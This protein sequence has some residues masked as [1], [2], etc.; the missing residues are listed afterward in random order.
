RV[1]SLPRF[2]LTSASRRGSALNRGL[3]VVG[4]L[5]AFG[6]SLSVFTATYDQ[7]AR[8]DAQ[9]TLGADVVATAPPGAVAKAHL[10]RTIAGVPGVGGTS[11]LDHTYAYVGPDLQDTFGIDPRTLP[12]AA[13]LRNSYFLG[14]SA[15]E[16]LRRLRARPDAVL[17]SRE[18]VTDYSLSEGD[19]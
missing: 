16:M 11:A 3:I 12:R 4:L 14:G 17:V 5:L 8:V 18:T 9:L 2:L 15:T 10:E 6:V 1:S 13:A 19:L 7:Q